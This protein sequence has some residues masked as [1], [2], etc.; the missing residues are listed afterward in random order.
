METLPTATRHELERDTG[1]VEIAVQAGLSQGRNSASSTCWN[2]WTNFRE[3][4]GLEAYIAPME[5]PVGEARIVGFTLTRLL[6]SL[7][8]TVYK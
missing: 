1:L 3:Q 7:Q 5:D 8:S 6:Q 4:H 2:I